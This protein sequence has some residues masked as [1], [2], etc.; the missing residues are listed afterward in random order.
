MTHQHVHVRRRA[1]QLLLVWLLTLASGLVNACV[2]QPG[3]MQAQG[4]AANGM[5]SE[6]QPL[7]G[8]CPECP[9]AAKPAK[10]MKATPCSKACEDA[11][12]SV[13][14]AK[15]AFDAHAGLTL[16]PL[17]TL[18]LALAVSAVQVA[19]AALPP[20]PLPPAAPPISITL[21]RLAL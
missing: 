2:I 6:A 15:P 16:A 18:G 14:S 10:A 21:Q 11:S 3:Q 19:D 13:T 4:L 8:H 5:S 17:L 9:P 7:K 12:G 20:L 1:A